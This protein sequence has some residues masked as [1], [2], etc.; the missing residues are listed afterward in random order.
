MEAVVVVAEM[1]ETETEI[2]DTEEGGPTLAPGLDPERGP[3]GGDAPGLETGEEG[4]VETGIEEEEIPTVLMVQ[5]TEESLEETGAET[6]EDL[7]TERGLTDLSL[8]H[9]LAVE[10]AMIER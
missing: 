9:L 8:G 7:V 6:K 1:G 2:G 5:G 10:R 4:A 3:G